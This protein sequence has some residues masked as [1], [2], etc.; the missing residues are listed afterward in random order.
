MK[1]ENNSNLKTTER[2]SPSSGEGL[3]SVQVKSRLEDGLVNI[4]SQ[5]YSKSYLSIFASNIFTVFNLLGLIVFISLLCVGAGLFDFVFVLVYIANF[6][7]GIIQE[8]RAKKCIEKLSLVA[9]KNVKAI[10]DG[11]EV[12]IAA[13]DI[14]QFLHHMYLQ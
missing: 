11:K 12:E 7:I 2:F 5:K 13:T 8:I 6:S 1:A 3:S 4:S 14:V 10:R 9:Q